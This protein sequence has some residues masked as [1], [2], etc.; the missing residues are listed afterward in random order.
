MTRYALPI[1][2]IVAGLAAVLGA[3]IGA[4]AIGPAAMLERLR[5]GRGPRGPRSP[6]GSK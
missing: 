6:R 3:S 5:R 4:A 2:L 1:L